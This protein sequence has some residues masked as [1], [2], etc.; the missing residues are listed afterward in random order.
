MVHGDYRTGNFLFDEE[1]AEITA[2]LDWE[3]ARTWVTTTRTSGGC[4]RA[5]T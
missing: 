5:S 3:W 2:I 4:C 1:A